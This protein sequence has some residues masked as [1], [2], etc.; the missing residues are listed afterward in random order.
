MTFKPVM[1]K[2]VVCRGSRYSDIDWKNEAAAF[3]ALKSQL[4]DWYIEPTQELVKHPYAGFTVLALTSVLIDTLSQYEAGKSKSSKLMFKKWLRD[5]IPDSRASLGRPITDPS[6]GEEISDCADAV[7]NAYR[8]GILHEAHPPI[9]CGIA[10]EGRAIPEQVD[11]FSIHA[12]GFTR[13]SDNSDCPTVVVN[14]N[15]LF[16]LVCEQFETYF[17]NLLHASPCF[18]LLR[19]KFKIKFALSHG[20]EIGNVKK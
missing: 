9:Y 6:T 2:R 16:E 17:A 10:G 5:K 1:E 18:D 8:C 13:Y 14:P 11:A 3:K 4:E 20:I 15:K 19:E 7:Y 12:S